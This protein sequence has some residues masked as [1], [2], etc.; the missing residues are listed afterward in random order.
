MYI[1]LAVRR[2]GAPSSLLGAS[3]MSAAPSLAPPLADQFL[4]PLEEEA[5]GRPAFC[6]PAEP[7]VAVALKPLRGSRVRAE[8]DCFSQGLRHGDELDLASELQRRRFAQAC[9]AKCPGS[10][11]PVYRTL[12]DSAK[13]WEQ[14]H[15]DCRA[16]HVASLA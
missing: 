12:E 3:P 11:R 15:P 9:D 7:E 2:S 1:I 10:F 8:A 5:A 6:W 4:P 13:A 16:D 14:V